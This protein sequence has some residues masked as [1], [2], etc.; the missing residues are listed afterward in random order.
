[1]KYPRRLFII[2]SPNNLSYQVCKD[3][4]ELSVTYVSFA[5]HAAGLVRIEAEKA[6]ISTKSN[7]AILEQAARIAELEANLAEVFEAGGRDV[8]YWC[9]KFEKESKRVAELEAAV[10]TS[11]ERGDHWTEEALKL[12]QSIVELEA[13]NELLKEAL[14]FYATR[15]DT[16]A[17]KTLNEEKS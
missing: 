4:E 1:M 9:E 15:S 11:N 3:E 12:T 16:K 14:K 7:Q 5:E 8:N 6:A 2:Q 13:V 10:Q 17:A